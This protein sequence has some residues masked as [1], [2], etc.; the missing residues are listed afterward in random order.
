[1]SRIVE[2]VPNFSEGRDM[3]I[4][5]QITDAMTAVSGVSLLDV[6][7]G[8]DTN[9]TVV[10]I[11]GDPDAVAEAAFIGIKRAAELI[12]MTQH[13]GT[14]PRMGAT[15]V[16]PFVPVEGITLEECAEIAVKVGKRVGEELKI[17]VYLYEAAAT[18]PE[19][20]NL[21]FVRKGEYEGLAERV[22]KKGIN[23]DFCD[24]FN[25]K[26]GATAISAR[27]FLVAYNV[28]LNTRDK[29][30]ATDIAFELREKGRVARTA[31]SS[32]LYSKGEMIRYA[33]GHFPCGN[34]EQIFASYDE[35]A[36]HCQTVHGY[37]LANLLALNDVPLDGLIGR[38]VYRAGKFTHAK[39]IGW[40]VDAYDRAQISIN[41][42]NYEITSMFDVLEEARRLATERGVVVTGSEI[43]G[44]VPYAALI[45]D[46]KKYLE[47]QGKT[48][49]VP[50]VDLVKTAIYSLGL[51]DVSPFE[52][53]SR[54]LGLPKADELVAKTVVDFT[55]EVSRDTPAPGGGSIA[56]LA[57]SLGAALA[58]MVAALT[59]GT[60]TDEINEELQQIT[61]SAQQVKDALLKGVDADTNAFNGYMDAMR[62]PKDTDEQKAART[63]RMQAEL[64]GAIAVPM[65]TAEH[66]LEAMKLA[67]RTT[68]IGN[69]NSITDGAVGCQMGFAAVRGACWNAV[70][71]L[72]G[73]KDDAYVAEIQARCD[74]LLTRAR[75]LLAAN[76]EF[77]DGVLLDRI[78]K[79]K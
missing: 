50:E 43:V 64:K 51:T 34:C 2:C 56:A 69:P 47:R 60:K 75:E 3:A 59:H 53:E 61:V 20:R 12:D 31:T 39:A 32:P 4:I 76:G 25:P 15:D 41:L 7:P 55:D 52:I 57:G 6:D 36:Q 58:S 17:P 24:E 29:A 14:H 28:T 73:I 13:H 74:E 35:V 21:A 11:V 68:E 5:K 77:V 26:A 38:A 40:F 8:A 46:A 66:S 72:K 63:A 67:A 19:R 54:V 65:E 33:E 22:G 16:C 79:R 49:G 9:R 44:L 37:D 70:I 78:N 27:P 10:T 42:T 71:N 45:Q 1:M 23:P 62:M 48:P 18:S 30:I